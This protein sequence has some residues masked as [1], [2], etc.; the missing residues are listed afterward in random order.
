MTNY[1]INCGY[2][3]DTAH[4]VCA[5][6]SLLNGVPEC[7]V[8]ITCGDDVCYVTANGEINLDGECQHAEVIHSVFV[9]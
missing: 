9:I 8:P 4:I 3:T 2:T 6:C 5:E 1:C 7:F